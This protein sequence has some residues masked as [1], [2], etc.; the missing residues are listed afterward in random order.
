MGEL[1][2][3]KM[4]QGD[5]IPTHVPTNSPR[6][7]LRSRMTH[8]KTRAM[9]LIAAIAVVVFTGWATL[10]YMALGST[11]T[12]KPSVACVAGPTILCL[13]GVAYCMKRFIFRKKEEGESIKD[14][15]A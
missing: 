12:L 1:M 11:Y 4:S 10:P 13:A 14:K 8:A 7:C 6:A 3:K 15:A 5:A 9:A 2:P